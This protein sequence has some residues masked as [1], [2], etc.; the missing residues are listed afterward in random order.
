MALRQPRPTDPKAGGFSPPGS[1]S[2]TKEKPLS[3]WGHRRDEVPK[4]GVRLELV[5]RCRTHLWFAL[6]TLTL[7]F[8]GCG[9]GEERSLRCVDTDAPTAT[10]FLFRFDEGAESVRVESSLDAYMGDRGTIEATAATFR[11]AVPL[12]HDSL[13][14][15]NEFRVDRFAGTGRMITVDPSGEVAKGTVSL[16]LECERVRPDERL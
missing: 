6:L 12:P 15:R 11:I 1:T 10:W 4:S 3:R 9:G 8:V 5:V 7:A 16:V 14:R 2:T 13:G